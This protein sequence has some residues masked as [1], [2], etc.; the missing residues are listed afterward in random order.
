MLEGKFFSTYIPAL[1]ISICKLHKTTEALYNRLNVHLEQPPNTQ[2]FLH[3]TKKLHTHEMNREREGEKESEREREREKER[4]REGGKEGEGGREGGR[5]RERERERE[6]ERES[7]KPKS[8]H[9]QAFQQEL[10]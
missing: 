4:G 6:K 9:V 1:K 7:T 3:D 10:D 2:S 5:E 8:S